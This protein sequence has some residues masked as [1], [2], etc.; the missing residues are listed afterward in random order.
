MSNKVTDLPIIARVGF[1][2]LDHGVHSLTPDGAEFFKAV[3]WNNLG[4]KMCRP[5]LAL[6]R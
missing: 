3:I 5:C 4:L 2:P 6:Y 1:H